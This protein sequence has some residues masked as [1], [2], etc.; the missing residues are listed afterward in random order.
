MRKTIYSEQYRALLGWLKA[1]RKSRKLSMRALAER[2]SVP[3]TWVGKMEQAERRMDIAEYVRLCE[4]LQINPHD[5]LDLLISSANYDMHSDS[6]KR[7][8]AIAAERRKR[9]S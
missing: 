6:A 7:P 4:A 3:H 1:C 8:P 2:L 5:G 9:Y